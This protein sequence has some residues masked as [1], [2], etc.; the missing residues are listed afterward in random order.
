LEICERSIFVL[1]S[2]GSL[3]LAR[4]DREAD[5]PIVRWKWTRTFSASKSSKELE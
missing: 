1:I 2:S 3:R 4:D 5:V